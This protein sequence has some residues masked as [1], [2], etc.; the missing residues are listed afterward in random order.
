MTVCYTDVLG[1]T[2]CPETSV[3]NCHLSTLC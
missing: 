1:P 3:A 2:G